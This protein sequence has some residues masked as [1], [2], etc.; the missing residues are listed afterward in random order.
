MSGI[1]QAPYPSSWPRPDAQ[2]LEGDGVCLQ[3]LCPAQHGDALF[4]A[5]NGH[6]ALWRYLPYGA[7]EH[8]DAFDAWLQMR[9]AQR[10]QVTY[11][12]VLPSCGAVGLISLMEIRPQ[13]GV[14][15]IGHVLFAP[16]LQET[17]A[18]TQVL[19]L[20][21]RHLFADLGYRRVEW[22]CNALN[23]ASQQAALRY[24]FR[25]EGVFHQ[26]MIVKGENR[27][28]AWFAMLDSSWPQVKNGFDRWLHQDNF[29]TA[30]RQRASLSH[31]MPPQA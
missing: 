30:G 5:V 6:D 16:P 3:R 23:Q 28:T 7:F 26:H 4:A 9:A 8:K 22:K 10:D 12:I 11:A 21:L 13:F 2:E 1:V 14:A 27:D 24:G 17:R 29:D 18:A 25:F 19:Y 31:F 15:E 20:L